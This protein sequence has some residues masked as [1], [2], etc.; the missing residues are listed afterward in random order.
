M[1]GTVK[2]SQGENGL[3]HNNY[4]RYRRFCSRKI[5]RMR[6]KIGQAGRVRNKQYNA[7]HVDVDW[8]K[9]K[10]DVRFVLVPLFVA[11]RAWAYG[12]Q[13]KYDMETF[14]ENSRLRH[15][16][17]R[18]MRKAEDAA[19]E[20]ATLAAAVGDARLEL[21]AQAYAAWIQGSHAFLR[22]DW[23]G[24]LTAY[25]QAM[26]IFDGLAGSAVQMARC[27]QFVADIKTNTEY[28][29]YQLRRASGGDAVTVEE[30]LELQSNPNS[31]LNSK[32]NVRFE[33]PHTFF[34]A[35]H[36]V[37]GGSHIVVLGMMNYSYGR[38][39]Y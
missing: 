1:L 23:E 3:K 33:T 39:E 6:Y 37:G 13:L 25:V 20:F 4:E 14:P 22:E 2:D 32:L 5:R 8:V 10:G 9:R 30:L 19:N 11:E 18:R 16:M 17:L 38:S 24:A 7:R 12:M 34:P 21:E 28:C 35:R 15:H 29:E 26:T 31:L 27:S 36:G